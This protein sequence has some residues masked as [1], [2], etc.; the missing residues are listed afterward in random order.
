MDL[1]RE[2]KDGALGTALITHSNEPERNVMLIA[3]VELIAGSLTLTGTKV[4]PL[5][6]NF[7]ELVVPSLNC[8]RQ[9]YSDL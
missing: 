3:A 6:C 8:L 5:R 9:A 7:G 1:T 4:A 2:T